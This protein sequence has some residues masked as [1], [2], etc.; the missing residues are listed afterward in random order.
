[1][2]PDPELPG[3]PRD[4]FTVGLGVA[5]LHRAL[6][7]HEV[8]PEPFPFLSALFPL[9]VL[10]VRPAGPSPG[11][12][13]G[14]EGWFGGGCLSVCPSV[15][16]TLVWLRWIWSLGCSWLSSKCFGAINVCRSASRCCFA[17]LR[18]GELK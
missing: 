1:M 9:F 12:L 5:A 15:C 10:R 13:K 3:P 17:G 8:L 16:L 2:R 7:D 4:S 14:C 18:K 6:K 11:G